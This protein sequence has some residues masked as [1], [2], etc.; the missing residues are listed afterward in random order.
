MISAKNIMIILW[1]N[2]LLFVIG[3]DAAENKLDVKYPLCFVD[4]TRDKQV[5][6]KIGH[7]HPA[8]IKEVLMLPYYGTH[9]K[10]NS[11]YER[12]VSRPFIYKPQTKIDVPVYGD[13]YT[14]RGIIVICPGYLARG[15][16]LTS[17]YT[18][19]IE[20]TTC[21]L[22]E[23]VKTRDDKETNRVLL[24]F[25]YLA[26]Q[27]EVTIGESRNPMDIREDEKHVYA[28]SMDL[29]TPSDY[30][31]VTSRNLSFSH[32]IWNYE[33]G[34]KIFIDLTEKEVDK[35]NEFIDKYLGSQNVDTTKNDPEN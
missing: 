35:V 10:K 33:S 21:T 20:E 30:K 22:V 8:S 16:P 25:K 17:Y 15:I 5:F 27:K 32:S 1:F 19:K 24:D 4:K 11:K 6:E 2:S 3:C 14:L 29:T 9:S 13:G 23:I 7:I 26:G 31:Y 34:T 18:D 12:V 28:L